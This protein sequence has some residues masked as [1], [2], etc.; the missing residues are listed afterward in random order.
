MQF[1]DLVFSYT[2]GTENALTAKYDMH[3]TEKH[4]HTHQPGSANLL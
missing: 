3:L 4:M 1:A 2:S